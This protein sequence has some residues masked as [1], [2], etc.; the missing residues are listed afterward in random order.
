MRLDSGG[1]AALV[2]AIALT[3]FYV[4]AQPWGRLLVSSTDLSFVLVAGAT[5]FLG[6]LVVLKWRGDGSLGHVHA[7][8]FLLV[9][10]WFLGE[11]VWMIY[12]VVLNVPIPYPSIADVFYLAGYFPGFVGIAQFV[13]FFRGV[14]T[15]ARLLVA[16]LA[17]LLVLATTGILLIQPILAAPSDRVTEAFDLAYPILDAAL[18]TFTIMMGAV[19]ERGILGKP[20]PWIALGLA[21][22]TAADIGFSLG[23]LSGWYYSGDPIELLWLF[24]YISMALG[25]NIQ[26]KM[27]NGRTH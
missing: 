21:L 19:L 14:I 4:I 7:G 6:L 20:Y 16:T 23:T 2:G 12:E 25:F 15:K 5:S 22:S 1:V 3:A 24:G 13:R 17:G 26:R 11:T 8:L 18:L 9:F 10:L 27:L